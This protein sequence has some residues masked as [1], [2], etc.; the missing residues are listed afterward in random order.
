MVQGT[1]FFALQGIGS[2]H[3]CA[4]HGSCIATSV[5]CLSPTHTRTPYQL[6]TTG[7]HAFILRTRG[8]VILSISVK[9]LAAVDSISACMV[10]STSLNSV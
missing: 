1:G 7:M 6:G 5:V 8:T 4:A 9:D 3:L 10:L 2:V